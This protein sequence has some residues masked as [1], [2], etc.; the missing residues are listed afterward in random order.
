[1]KLKQI[2]LYV[3]IALGFLTP[4]LVAAQTPVG[5]AVNTSAAVTAPGASATVS[6]TASAKLT[7]TEVKAKARGDAEIGRRTA[8][9]MELNTRVQAMQKVTD[10]FKQ[11]IAS[12]IQAQ[13]TAFATLKTK[14]DA[15]TDSATLKADLQSVTDS[16]RIFALVMPQVRI[17]AAADREVTL[18]S[19]MSTMGAKLQA[20]IQ[21][22]SQVGA[23]VKAVTAALADMAAKLS[24]AQTQA[25]ASVSTS[26][27]LAPDNGDKTVMASNAAALKTARTSIQAAQ[28]DIVA[29][30]K[31]INTILKGLKTIDASVAASS[32]TQ[33]KTQ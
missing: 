13:L 4:V 28:A 25:T 3:A 10:S 32:T 26:A 6:A 9:L 27:A 7:A 23:D 19:M 21:A 15:D 24:D 1:M 20:R 31:D 22:A 16:Y 30:R 12:A 5:A 11:N 29:A 33:I 2:A 14:I 18:V 17:A 8:A